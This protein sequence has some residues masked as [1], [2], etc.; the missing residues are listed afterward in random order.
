MPVYPN[1]STLCLAYQI[2]NLRRNESN[3]ARYRLTYT[4]KNPRE[5]P[6]DKRGIRRTVAYIWRGIKGGEDEEA[7]YI[8]STLEQSINES[9]ADDRLQIDISKLEQG[10]YELA[11]TVED[12]VS[13]QIASEN[14]IFLI[15][16]QME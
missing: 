9:V 5:S 15:T 10:R 1:G 4:I 16:G 3:Q 6:E 12:L 14:R 13:G 11:L 2:Y 7:P 8:T